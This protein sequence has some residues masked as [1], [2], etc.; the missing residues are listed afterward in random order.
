MDPS[1]SAAIADQA[2]WHSSEVGHP[3]D[4]RGVIVKAPTRGTLRLLI[5]IEILLVLGILAV[6]SFG[7]S[8]LPEP[9]RD[10]NAQQFEDSDISTP[11]LIAASVFAVVLLV[12][13]VV[14]W[15]GLLLFWRPARLLYFLTMVA[16]LL[17]TP[18][19]GPF[20]E[21]GLSHA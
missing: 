19:L 21:T 16:T 10:F 3:T 5:V 9:L 8:S 4:A 7:S 6:D 18:F 14:A 12:A 2:G 15:I 20:V 11:A 1:I 13:L 17:A